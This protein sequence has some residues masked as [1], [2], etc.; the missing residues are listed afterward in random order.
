[1]KAVRYLNN[2]I[3]AQVQHEDNVLTASVQEGLASSSYS[4]GVLLDKEVLVKQFGDFVRSRIPVASLLFPPG[5]SN[6]LIASD[7]KS[8]ILC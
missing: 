2:R 7:S 6:G 4:V 3:N 8:G 5:E 1:M